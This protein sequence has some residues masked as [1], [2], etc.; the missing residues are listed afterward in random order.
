MAAI[1]QGMSCEGEFTEEPIAS[2]KKSCKE[3][4]NALTWAEQRK[5]FGRLIKEGKSPEEA[6]AAMPRCQ[7]C[8]TRLLGRKTPQWITPPQRRVRP[9]P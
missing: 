9:W 3:C 5:Q 1:V 7:K 2:Q 4:K 8:V 6:K